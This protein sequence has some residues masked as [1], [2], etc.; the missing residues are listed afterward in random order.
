MNATTVRRGA[1]VGCAPFDTPVAG[2]SAPREKS[3]MNAHSP[4]VSRFR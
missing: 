4:R 3:V 1:P 2:W